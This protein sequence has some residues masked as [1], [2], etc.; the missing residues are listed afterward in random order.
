V[1]DDR[2]DFRN[3]HYIPHVTLGIYNANH[4]VASIAAMI[5][6]LKEEPIELTVNHI[7]LYSYDARDI[8]S[9]L[10]KECITALY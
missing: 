2:Q 4:T 5:K 3:T 9:R 10:R 6:D 1:I 8:G 7:G